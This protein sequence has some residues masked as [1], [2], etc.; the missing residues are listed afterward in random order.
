MRRH[1]LDFPEIVVPLEV[2]INVANRWS[3]AK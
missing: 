1:M 2:D 3:E